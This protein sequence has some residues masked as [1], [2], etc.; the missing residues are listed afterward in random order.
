MFSITTSV[1]FATSTKRFKKFGR[2]MKDQRRDDLS[3]IGEKIKDIARDE[4]RRAK[5]IFREHREFFNG[6]SKNS[7][8]KEDL[9]IDFFEN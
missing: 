2:K 3:K 7:Q 1:T 9:A 4:E 8:K 6:N 5:D